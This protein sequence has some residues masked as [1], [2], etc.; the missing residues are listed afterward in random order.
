MWDGDW[1]GLIRHRKE[2]S[3]VFYECGIETYGSR[4]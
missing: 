2:K 3:E 4:I 1:I